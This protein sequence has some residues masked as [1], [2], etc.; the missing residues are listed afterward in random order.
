MMAWEGRTLPGIRRRCG[1]C[2]GRAVSGGRGGRA[3]S[4]GRGGR[5]VPGGRGIAHA[6]FTALF[7]GT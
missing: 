5:A 6:L 2:G 1:R 3:V 4:G 7:Q